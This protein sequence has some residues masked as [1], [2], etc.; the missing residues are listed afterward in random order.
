MHER[1]PDVKKYPPL[2]D[3]VLDN[4]PYIPWAFEA[5]EMIGVVLFAVLAL[6]LVFHKHRFA[7]SFCDLALGSPQS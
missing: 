6:V 2:P 4:V 5:A 7:S 1:V 3:I